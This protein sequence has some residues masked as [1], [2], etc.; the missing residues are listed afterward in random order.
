MQSSLGKQ[1]VDM[2]LFDFSK[3]FDSDRNS[4]SSDLAQSDIVL[5]WFRSF[6]SH[7]PQTVIIPNK[8]C[9]S[10]DFPNYIYY[11]R[12]LYADDLKMYN[13]AEMLEAIRSYNNIVSTQNND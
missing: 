3:A 6:L 5:I 10:G 12:Y 7:R 2:I 9:S 8:R 13:P 1:K 11:S 4:Q